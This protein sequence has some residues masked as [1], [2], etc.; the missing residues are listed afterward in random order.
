MDI[1]AYITKHE[2]ERLWAY[3][4]S[5][6]IWTMGVGF[7][8]ERDGANDAMKKA[9]IDPDMIWAAIEEAKKAGKAVTSP[10]INHSQSMALLD[11]DVTACIDDLRVGLFPMFY[12]MPEPARMVLMDLRFQLGP[13]RLRQFKN[14][15]K[16]FT[17][18]RWK[19]AGAGIKASA[20]YKQVPVRC[21]E[22]IALLNSI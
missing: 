3:K 11:A 2:G 18:S 1:K 12:K 16:A 10:L 15:L 6:G 14:T 9:G 20:M 7:N 5:L 22:N 21:D 19:D 13:S 8:I 17:E 4:D